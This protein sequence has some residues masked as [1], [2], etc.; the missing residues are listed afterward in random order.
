[1]KK[2]LLFLLFPVLFLASCSTAEKPK[3]TVNP[4]LVEFE[5]PF[6]APPFDIIDNEHYL[7]AYTVAM[8]EHKADIQAIVDNTDAPDF[9][10]TIVAYD[11]SGK[12][13]SKIS[14]IFGG[15]RG[16]NTN[17]RL[18]EIAREITPLLSAHSNE[19]RFNQGLFE[20][21]KAVY[22]K[23]ETLGLN[24]EQLRLTEKIY[25]DFARNGAALPEEQ[26]EEL[27]SLN[28]QMSMLSLKLGENL[29][30]E[31]NGF[32]LVLDKQEDLAGLPQNV[33][34]AAADEAKKS[35][36]EGKWVFT[37]A[38]PSWIPFLQFSQ[39]R[40]LREQ[41]YTAYINRGDN[42]NANDNKATFLELMEMRKKMANLLG[43]ENYA[44]YFIADQMA[45]TP[46][47]VYDFLYQ[48]WEPSIKRA[49]L[50]R[51]EQQAIIDKTGGDFKLASWDWWYYSEMVRK[52]KFDLNEDDIKPYFAIE[53]VKNGIFTLTTKLFGLT[54]VKNTEIPVYHPE[55]EAYEVYNRDGGNQGVLFIDPHP[56]PEKRSGAWCGT[57]RNGG[58]DENGNKILPIVTIVMNFTRP[59]G[60][61]P[62][63]LSWD[64]TRTYFHEFGHALHNLFADGQYNRTS[65]SVPRDFVELPSQILENWAGEPELLKEYAFHYQTGEVIPAELVEKLNK[66]AMFN[67][68]F[69]NAEYIAAA[70]LDMD[71][72][73]IALS[74]ETDVN[75]FEKATLDRIGLI[76]EIVPRY[77]TPNFGHI[78]ATGYAAGY[79]VYRWAGVLDADAFMA[80]KESGDLFNQ[81]LAEKF[82]KYVLAE[83][84]LWEGMDAYVKFRGS[85]PSIDP[86]LIRSGLK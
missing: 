24:Q 4:L 61:Q 70:I 82:R 3:E 51:D 2:I 45:E 49:K 72:H 9:E 81:E 73:T 86:F 17:P 5:T 76:S 84:G 48:V 31:N 54:F 35:G 29:L 27:K 23:R 19:I 85:E 63:L 34:A 40:D 39:R 44:E 22:E 12:L 30:A 71:W 58:Y 6:G 21:I 60:D 69:E 50:E 46:A 11:R 57:Y 25:Q 83:N 52:E 55:V 78:H 16:A 80:F 38:K 41:L 36:M 67:Q 53:N 47:N 32:K 8:E 79:Y 65:R 56:R 74:P 1:M 28:Q 10:N 77:R 42:N 68:G 64:E 7:P 59:V 66:S 75:A 14:P 33:I 26:R 43:Y 20:R 13:M 37:L 15:L 62:A 18:Q